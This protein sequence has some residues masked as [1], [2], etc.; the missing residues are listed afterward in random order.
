MNEETGWALSIVS[1]AIA[2]RRHV[3]VRDSEEAHVDVPVL[4]VAPPKSEPALGKAA[5]A[6]RSGSDPVERAKRAG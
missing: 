5:E 4:F 3:C 1:E 2:R 6:Q